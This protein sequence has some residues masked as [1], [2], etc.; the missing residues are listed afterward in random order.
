MTIT[1]NPPGSTQ[2]ADGCVVTDAAPVY[3][4]DKGRWVPARCGHDTDL[5]DHVAARTG[6][7]GHQRRN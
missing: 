4:A 6:Q 3:D 5:P 7:A 1:T 2:L